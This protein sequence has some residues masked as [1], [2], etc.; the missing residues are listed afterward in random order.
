MSSKCSSN[1]WKMARC[2][3]IF[4]PLF[5]KMTQNGLKWIYT[6]LHNVTFWTARP[7]TPNVTFVTFFLRRAGTGEVVFIKLRGQG[8]LGGIIRADVSLSLQTHSAR[9]L[10]HSHS[11]G[12]ISLTWL[13]R[14]WRWGHHHHQPG[15]FFRK[16]ENWRDESA[17]YFV[18]RVLLNVSQG[19]VT[20]SLS[21]SYRCSEYCDNIVTT[22]SR[23][24]DPVTLQP[25]VLMMLMN[26]NCG[27]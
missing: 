13:Q 3:P 5:Y 22:L 2:P 10:K 21:R 18:M 14:R 27:C 1:R 9:P 16:Q 19:R 15:H 26:L 23:W 20:L 24:W 25:W 4:R 7:P 8:M 17:L 11:T 6:T 12:N